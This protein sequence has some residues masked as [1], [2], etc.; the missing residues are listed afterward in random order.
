MPYRSWCFAEWTWW[1][2]S[3][4]LL[5]V[6]WS[7]KHIIG[8]SDDEANSAPSI[9]HRSF[10][11]F[12]CCPLACET[13]LAPCIA[14]SCWR[15]SAT[16]SLRCWAAVALCQVG[17]LVTRST[18]PLP[19]CTG[20]TMSP[21]LKADVAS[22][23]SQLSAWEHLLLSQCLETRVMSS[24]SLVHLYSSVRLVT[25]SSGAP[26][27]DTVGMGVV[28]VE[29]LVC[30]FPFNNGYAPRFSGFK[31]HSCPLYV[32]LKLFHNCWSCVQGGHFM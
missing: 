5:S 3:N 15:T 19:C 28:D 27:Y 7:G 18:P 4:P 21:Y 6:L 24:L 17:W 2:F 32:W 16:T 12:P 25:G 1:I 31:P 11:V 8:G 10:Q 14:S 23:T 26:F 20:C 13:A 22:P 30:K 9:S 29:S